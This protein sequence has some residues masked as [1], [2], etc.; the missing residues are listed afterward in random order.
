MLY[1]VIYVTCYEIVRFISFQTKALRYVKFSETESFDICE[2]E[3]KYAP[4]VA[5]LIIELM[6]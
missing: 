4:Y 5:L 6:T 2:R 1:M 3:K